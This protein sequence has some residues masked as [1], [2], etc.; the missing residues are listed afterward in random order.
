MAD[1]QPIWSESKPIYVDQGQLSVLVSDPAIDWVEK[2]THHD[3]S[4]RVFVLDD[5]IE[6]PFQFLPFSILSDQSDIA[7]QFKDETLL[8]IDYN[9]QRLAINQSSSNASLAVDGTIQATYFIGN[10]GDLTNLTGPG[11]NDGHSLNSLNGQFKD[12]VFVSNSANVGIHTDSPL[13]RLH[14]KGS[15]VFKSDES[16]ILSNYLVPSGSVLLWDDRRASFRSGYFF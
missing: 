6:M 1:G 12:V 9:N 5:L 14:I 7:R 8:N 16:N 15:I 2:L 10:G 4:F 11:F 13:A 3:L